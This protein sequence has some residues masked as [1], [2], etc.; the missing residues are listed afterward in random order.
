LIS[1]NINHYLEMNSSETH[2]KLFDYK[3]AD[4]GC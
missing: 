1:P 3:L 2:Q 4:Y